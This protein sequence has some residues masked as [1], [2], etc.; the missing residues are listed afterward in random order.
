MMLQPDTDDVC[1]PERRAAS[2]TCTVFDSWKQLPY[3]L[4][5]PP[6]TQCLAAVR[7]LAVHA[8]AYIDAGRILP[9]ARI[10]VRCLPA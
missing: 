3:D 4:Q 1:Q 9:F 5:I 2:A 10:L 8:P 7:Q 6:E